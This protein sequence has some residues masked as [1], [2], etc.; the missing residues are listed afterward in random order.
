MESAKYRPRSRDEFEIAII[1]T[2]PCAT[3]AILVAMDELWHEHRQDY[4]KLSGDDNS[5]DFGRMGEHSVVVTTLASTGLV[6]AS[7]AARSLKMSFNFIK[8]ALL[9]GICGA[10]PFKKDGSEILLG[11]VVIGESIVELGH[12]RVLPGGFMRKDKLIEVHGRPSEEVLGLLRRW[13]I[14]FI[15]QTLRQGSLRH[16]KRILHCLGLE[17][18]G[19]LKDK[20]FQSEYIHKHRGH[21]IDCDRGIASVCQPALSAPCSDTFCD[22][23]QIVARRRLEAAVKANTNTLYPD[24]H[25]GSVGTTNTVVHSAKHRD[26]YAENEDIT[27]FETAAAGVW[28]KFNCVVIEGVCGYADSHENKTW[29][30]YA[31]ATAAAVAKEVLNQY[32]LPQRQPRSTFTN[33]KLF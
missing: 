14:P 21:C 19:L 31:A 23:S 13:Q 20:L 3:N 6:S 11:D 5:Y 26:R 18:P 25:I 33:G 8:L 24:I 27:A 28:G 9:V 16:L 1:C 29:H 15:F 22:E 2:V 30:N 12:G 4:G 32:V 7:S 10:I 17:Y